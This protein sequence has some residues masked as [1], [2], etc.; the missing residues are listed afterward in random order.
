MCFQYACEGEPYAGRYLCD[1]RLLFHY[2][3]GAIGC[4]F[5]HYVFSAGDRYSIRMIQFD[6]GIEVEDGSV[7]RGEAQTDSLRWSF[8]ID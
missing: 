1:N 7:V 2:D 3:V 8:T 4:Y 6:G 5:R